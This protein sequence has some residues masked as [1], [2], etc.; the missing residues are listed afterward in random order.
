MKLFYYD[1]ETT[2]TLFWKNGIHQIS[3]CIEIDGKVQDEFDFKV[4]PYENAVIVPDALKVAGVSKSQVMA[5]DSM[6]KTHKA[7]YRVLGKYV[8]KFDGKDKF[9]LVGYNNRGFDD[10]F[11]RAWF[12]QNND[13]YFGSWFWPDSIDVMV[14]ACNYLASERHKISN[15]K[16]ATVCE[17]VGIDVIEN[18]LHDATYDI[19]LTRALYNIVNNGLSK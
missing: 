1:L 17:Y 6:E 2:G 8:N 19:E 13:K 15:F 7:L 16:L 18:R 11:F 3:G 14:L 4:C 9:H 12:K 5:Y 10:P